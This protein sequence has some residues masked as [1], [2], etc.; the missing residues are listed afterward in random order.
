MSTAYVFA[1]YP[2][3]GA[4]LR[5]LEGRNRNAQ[6]QQQPADPAEMSD[7]ERRE[8]QQKLQ[9]YYR[10]YDLRPAGQLLPQIVANRV[11]RAVYSERQLQ[12]AMV[13]FWQNHF[14]VF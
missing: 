12:E 6:P 3:P 4:L 14:N 7:A 5:Q 13:D 10:E 9:E 11:L 8:R 2:N 1:K